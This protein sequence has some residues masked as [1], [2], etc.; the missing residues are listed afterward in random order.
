MHGF[1]DSFPVPLHLPLA[2]ARV[3]APSTTKGASNKGK[4][5][6]G[7][8]V[9]LYDV[10]KSWTAQEA[11]DVERKL[12]MAG[13]CACLHLRS[14]TN[15]A[16]LLFLTVGYSTVVLTLSLP[17]HF[18]PALLTFPTPLFPALD[19][20]TA[21][22]GTSGLILQLWKVQIVNYDDEAV[23]GAA[24]KGIYGFVS[25]LLATAFQRG[26]L[27]DDQ[28]STADESSGN[29][30]PSCCVGPGRVS[31]VARSLFSLL[32]FAVGRLALYSL[33]SHL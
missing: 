4:E 28:L 33:D 27:A 32:P 5:R 3:S 9:V 29:S 18:N 15:G 7:P 13:L 23:K 30:V 6:E 21:P 1:I 25:C 22:P 14:C 16:N 31:H 11:D 10:V 17:V 19:P 24:I 8:S 12:G 20:R 2:P 26:T